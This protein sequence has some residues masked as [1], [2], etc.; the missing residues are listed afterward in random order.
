LQ[1]RIGNG[2]VYCSNFISDDAASASLLQD[3]DGKALADPKP[4]Q[5]KAGRRKQSWKGNC[6]A[7]GLASGFLEPLEST[8]IYLIQIGITNL[9]K[10]FPNR[11][12]DPALIDEYNRLVDYEYERV[13]DFLI[14]HYHLNRRDDS[15]LWRHCRNMQVPDSLRQKMEMFRRRGYIDVYR[16]GLFAPPSWIAVFLGQG[17]EPEDFSPISNIIPFEEAMQEMTELPAAIKQRVQMMP[18]HG[19]FLA[20]YCP[21]TL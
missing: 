10:L 15:E 20:D 3:L 17:L 2:Y 8:S 19:V 13:R 7:V 5:F 6:I 16:Y 14:L 18:E 4:L 9:V 1:H 11:N 12:P 21:A